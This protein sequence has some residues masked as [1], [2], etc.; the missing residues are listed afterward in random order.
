MKA[1]P[2]GKY[3]VPTNP[4]KNQTCLYSLGKGKMSSFWYKDS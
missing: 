3:V 4:G 1:N 2:V